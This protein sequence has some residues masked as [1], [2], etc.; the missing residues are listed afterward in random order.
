LIDGCRLS[1]ATV[2]VY[3]HADPTAAAAALARPGTFRRRLLLT[4]SLFS[5]DGDA[6][7]LAALAE[8][9]A[10]RDAILVVDEAHALGT[11]GPAGR[12]LSAAAGVQP[13]VLVGTL[14]KAFGAAGGF[15]AGSR[16]LRAYLV[17]RARSFIFATAPPPPVAAAASAG[18]RLAASAEGDRR[19]ERLAANR[20]LLLDLL[21]ST[22]VGT[23]LG[24]A[25]APAFTSPILPIV[26]GPDALALAAAR[27]LRDLGLFVPAIRPPTVPEGTA[28]LR[29]TFSSEHTTDEVETL[30]R[31]LQGILT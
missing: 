4:E 30:G 16:A 23:G 19:R 31:A 27:R 20:S 8:L 25:A 29:I 15:V 11:T 6:A 13:D 18:V 22:S 14:G 28:R 12:G 24:G 21:A 1:R 7:P 9:A 5:M 10:A 3:A 26:L 17:N 2:A